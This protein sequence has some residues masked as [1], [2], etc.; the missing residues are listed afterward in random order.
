M[1][2]VEE[3]LMTHEGK[4]RD[5]A[6]A[7]TIKPLRRWTQRRS[8]NKTTTVVCNMTKTHKRVLK[9]AGMSLKFESKATIEDRGLFLVSL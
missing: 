2:F 5:T 9:V 1:V 3:I 6:T 7:S 8:E 4:M